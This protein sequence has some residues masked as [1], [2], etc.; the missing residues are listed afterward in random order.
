MG[1]IVRLPK[2]LEDPVLDKESP[3]PVDHVEIMP[4][5]RIKYAKRFENLRKVWGDEKET[6]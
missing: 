5:T 3:E 1:C 2:S 4:E 6:V